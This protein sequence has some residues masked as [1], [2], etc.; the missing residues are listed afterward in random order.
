M[1]GAAGGGFGAAAPGTEGRDAPAP[2]AGGGFTFTAP[3]P[4]AGGSFGDAAFAGRY[5]V[6]R[7]PLG[8]S[9]EDDGRLVSFGEARYFSD[10]TSHQPW[11]GNMYDDEERVVSDDELSFY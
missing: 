10:D 7:R 8:S 11:S 6:R 3:A 2:A 4:A 9:D 1:G 5:R